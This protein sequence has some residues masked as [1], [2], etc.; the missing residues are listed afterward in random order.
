MATHPRNEV[1]GIEGGCEG[2]RGT[3]QCT[4]NNGDSGSSGNNNNNNN[5]KRARQRYTVLVLVCSGEEMR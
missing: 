1:L 4:G 2:N 3:I 5:E